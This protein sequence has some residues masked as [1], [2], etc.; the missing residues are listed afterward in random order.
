[1]NVAPPFSDKTLVRSTAL[2]LLILILTT[3]LGPLQAFLETVP[4][5][6]G[7]WLACTGAALPVLVLSEARVLV[8][9][10]RSQTPRGAER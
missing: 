5:D 9:H 1:M 10:R 4:L 2:S 8:H 6:T 7:Q 3:V